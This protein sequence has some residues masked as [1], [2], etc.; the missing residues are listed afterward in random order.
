MEVGS[1]GRGG[2]DVG[3]GLNEYVGDGLN[4]LGRG[5]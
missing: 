1:L 3:G 4:D 5:F 2:E